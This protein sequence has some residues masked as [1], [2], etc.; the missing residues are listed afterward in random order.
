MYNKF[1]GGA[2]VNKSANRQM[3]IHNLF[4][5]GEDIYQVLK[6]YQCGGIIHFQTYKSCSVDRNNY[7]FVKNLYCL[8]SVYNLFWA[9]NSFSEFKK[10]KWAI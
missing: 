4:L 9:V 6:F 7:D 1:N 3:F 8:V 2:Q 10:K 5:K